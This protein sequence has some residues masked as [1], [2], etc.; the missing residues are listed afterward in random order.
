MKNRETKKNNNSNQNGIM[1]VSEV[2]AFLR[3]PTSTIYELANKGK[4]KGVK[5]SKHWR[6]LKEDIERYLYGDRHFSSI[7]ARPQDRRLSPRLKTE[8]SA[9]ISGD[10]RETKHYQKQGEIQNLSQEGAL[11]VTDSSDDLTKLLESGDPIKLC[12]VLTNGQDYPVEAEGRVVHQQ[13][14]GRAFYGIKFRG[15]T[16]K[17]KEVLRSYVG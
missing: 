12:F 7:P 4:I 16:P 6:F 9:S 3:I 2:S 15:L 13:V 10:L 8:L 1:T 17:Q 14:N 11:F 5:I